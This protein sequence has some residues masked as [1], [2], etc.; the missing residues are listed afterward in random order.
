DMRAA[1]LKKGFR[2]DNTHHEML[3]FYADNKKTSIKTRF[4][5][6][7]KEYDDKL[8]SLVRRQINLQTAL[9]FDRFMECPMGYTDNLALMKARGRVRDEKPPEPAPTSK[10]K[11]HK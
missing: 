5:Q 2:A 3:W 4:S 8:C 9:E 10:K 1:L 7:S 11:K 6:G